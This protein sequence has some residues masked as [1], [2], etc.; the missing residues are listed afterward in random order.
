M[1]KI[2][3]LI[4]MAAMAVS[5]NAQ[6]EWKASTLTFEESIL[7]SMTTTDNTTAPAYLIPKDTKQ[8]AQGTFPDNLSTVKSWLESNGA[9]T[10]AFNLKEYTFTASTAS[11]SMKAVSTPNQ[12]ASA[13]EAWQAAGGETSNVALNTDDC[14]LKWTT[15]VKP[16]NGNPSFGYYDYYDTNDSDEPVHRVQEDV[17]TVGSTSLPLKG[18]YYEFTF[19]Q[20][21][22]LDMGV[23][24]NRPNSS[25]VVVVEKESKAALPVSSLSFEGFCQNNGY[26][27]NE[28][29]YQK[30]TF[31]DDYTI[32]VS[33]Q[34]NRP[35][36][37]YLSF[38]VEAKTY[39]VMM[40]TNQLGIY[41]FY[42]TPGDPAGINNVKA[43]QNADAPIYNLAGQKVDKSYKGVKV[44]NGK[45][46]F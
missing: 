34:V 15:Y 25:P 13:N 43:E 35:L 5:V 36:L 16:K 27:Y 37:G 2:F 9:A 41:G 10:Y 46:F 29:T 31:R 14:V 12:D 39:I 42:F 40:P 1:K 20:A 24:M 17:W 6:E 19:S 28:K 33:L 4:C 30:W 22:S 26:S 3:T 11:V 8:F 38:P 32:D 21:G 7:T 45:K 23:Y 44:Q 18:C